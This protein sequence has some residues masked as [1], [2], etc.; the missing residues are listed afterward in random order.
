MPFGKYK[1]RT[2]QSIA[3][4]DYDYLLWVKENSDDVVINFSA[5]NTDKY[6]EQL[7]AKRDRMLKGVWGEI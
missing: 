1:G 7:K 6:A 5:I 2:I 4:E 3:D